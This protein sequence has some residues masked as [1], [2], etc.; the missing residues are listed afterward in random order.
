[1]TTDALS[2]LDRLI[3]FPTVSRDGN[4]DL[5]RYVRELL[6]GAGIESR[7]F[8]DDSGDRASLFASVGN[9]P[10]GIVLSGHTDVV[11][12]DGQ[13][14]T[15]D[16][17]RMTQKDGR[18]YGRGTTDMK[19]YVACAI[20]AMIKAR[21]E[22]PKRPLHIALSYDEEIGCIGVRPM[23]GEL[24][25]AGLRP[26]WVM[27]GEPTSM[28]VAAGH[29]GKIGAR[30][31]CCG[32]A[33]HSALAPKGLNAIHLAADLLT[34]I[35]RL[36]AELAETGH[37]DS[38]YDIPYTTVHGGIIHGGTVLNIVPDHCTLDFEIRNLAQ[39][40]AGKLLDRLF[41]KAE[42]ISRPARHR[43]P[44]TGISIEVIN[45]YPGLDADRAHEPTGE[46]LRLAGVNRTIKVAYGTEGGLFNAMLDVPVVVCGP[47][48]MDQGHKPD[49]Y[50]EI[51][52]IELCRTVMDRL[53]G[54]LVA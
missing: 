30:A 48:S 8:P 42:Q 52:Q 7:L 29:K 12:V 31:T 4:I 25:K 11:P 2:I 27:V 21:K 15:R 38:D 5:I 35:R 9:G 16:P 6:D 1:M 50:V 33:A 14:W 36:Q 54:Q 53:V 23:L 34:E 45:E 20:E 41:D 28:Q 24:A 19:G 10:G 18:L 40:D 17:F 49:E 13:A 3:A 44:E 51:S 39:D 32:F 37:Q 26:D 46:A 22:P 43:F 47:G